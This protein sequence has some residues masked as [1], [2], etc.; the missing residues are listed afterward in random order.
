[1]EGNNTYPSD[2]IV[3]LTAGKGGN[4]GIGAGGGGGGHALA[5]WGNGGG[6]SG[7]PTFNLTHGIGGNGGPGLVSVW[8]VI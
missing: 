7:S 2:V 4:G 1:M 6:L 3:K 8:G 5:I